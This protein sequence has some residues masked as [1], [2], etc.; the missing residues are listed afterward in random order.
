M[1][2]VPFSSFPMNPVTTFPFPCEKKITVGFSSPLRF[3]NS[4]FS[5]AVAHCGWLIPGSVEK[6]QIVSIDLQITPKGPQL[7]EP[8]QWGPHFP[9]NNIVF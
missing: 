3:G 7:R 8:F 1:L 5:S 2:P 4:P 6:L 9:G